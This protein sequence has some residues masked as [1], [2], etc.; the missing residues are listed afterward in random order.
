MPK[1]RNHFIPQFLLRRFAS[2]QVGKRHWLWQFRVHS[3]PVEVVTENAALSTLFYGDPTTGVEDAFATREGEQA[4]LLRDLDAGGSPDTRANELR[5]CVWSLSLRT[6]AFR[7]QFTTMAQRGLEHMADA[8]EQTI[9]DAFVRQ[10]PKVLDQVM[11]GV[12]AKLPPDEA[13]GAREALRD[14]RVAARIKTLAEQ[15]LRKAVPA[16]RPLL[17]AVAAQLPQESESGHVG[18]LAALL[19]NWDAESS[20]IHLPRWTV[21]Q[22]PANTVVLGDSVAFAVGPD[23]ETGAVGRFTKDLVAVYAPISH[24]G[25]LVGRRDDSAP[26]L[27]LDAINTASAQ[28]SLDTL[29]ASRDTELE[30]TLVEHIGTGEPMVPESELRKLGRDNWDTFGVSHSV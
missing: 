3:E 5:K 2:R 13:R 15:Q 1:K 28:L 24:S 4:T 8:D 16:V 7:S 20:R 22:F 27:P 17:K 23:G 21:C 10:M 18:G 29:F 9:H 25:V 14:P 11:E 26:I 6:R 19:A 30:R 12:L